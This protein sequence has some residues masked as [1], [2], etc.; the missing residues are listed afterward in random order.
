MP[1]LLEHRSCASVRDAARGGQRDQQVARA[2][3]EHGLVAQVDHDLRRVRVEAALQR[4]SL[5]CAFHDR[6]AAQGH[7]TAQLLSPAEHHRRD[8]VGVAGNACERIED[9]RWVVLAVHEDERARA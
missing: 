9:D 1:G 7:R 6:K 5:R 4:F 8:D 3:I 2:R